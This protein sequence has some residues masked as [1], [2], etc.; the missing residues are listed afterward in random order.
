MDVRAT[1]TDTALKVAERLNPVMNSA[2]APLKTRALFAS[3]APSLMP[4]A[5]AH[6]GIAAGFR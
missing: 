1:A 6:Q 4:R 3:F 2:S 5:A